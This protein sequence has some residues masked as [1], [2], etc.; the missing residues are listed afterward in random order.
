MSEQSHRYACPRGLRDSASWYLDADP[1]EQVDHALVDWV[2]AHAGRE[3]LDL[4][5]GL[6]GYA[7]VL[8][9]RGL[10]VRGLDVVSAYVERAQQLGVDAQLYDG[11][12]VPAVDDS[13]DTVILLEVLEHLDDPAA[14]LAEARRVAR[15][16]VLVSVPDCTQEFRG[17]PVEFSHMLDVDHRQWFTVESLERLLRDVCGDANVQQTAAVDD[18]LAGL[19]LPR[20]L[21]PAYRALRRAGLARPRF[22]S[23]LLGRATLS[24]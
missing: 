11:G 12:R 3:L 20:P 23:R 16:N 13:V 2:M 24:A 5:C 19:I 4:G 14:L 8:G 9:E 17:V 6:G 10:S 21:R 1:L 7:K 22:Y 15:R 18:L